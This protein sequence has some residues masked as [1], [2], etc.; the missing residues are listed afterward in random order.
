MMNTIASFTANVDYCTPQNHRAGLKVPLKFA[1]SLDPQTCLKIVSR[2]YTKSKHIYICQNKQ[3]KFN[4]PWDNLRPPIA[5]I[6]SMKITHG[7]CARAYAN[8]YKCKV[9]D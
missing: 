6:S 3:T 9:I 4:S 2:E 1:E 7:A 8:I 5:S